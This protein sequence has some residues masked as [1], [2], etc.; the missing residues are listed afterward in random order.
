MRTFVKK[1]TEDLYLLRIDDDQTKYFEALWSIPEG[2]T[3]NAYLLIT[4]DKVVLFDSWKRT[5]ENEF[6]KCL[7]KVVDLKDIDY[8]VIHHMEQ[9]HSGAIPKVLEING[10]KAEV[11]GHPLVKKMLESFYGISPKFKA[12]ADGEE[13]SV[14]GKKLQFIRTPWLH[15]PET[16]MT[17]IS[18]DQ[19]L[20]SGDAFGGFS[21]PPTIIDDEKVVSEYLEHVRKYVVTIVGHYSEHILKAVEKLRTSGLTFKIIAPAHGL[22]FKNNPGLIVDYFVKLAKGIPEKNKIVVVYSSMYGSVEKA[23]LAAVEELEKNNFKPVIHKFTDTEQ[24]NIG[25]VISNIVDAQAV[26]IGAATYE[27][28]VFPYIRYLLDLLDKK[29]KLEKPVLVISS[30]GWGGVA[31][32]KISKKL[33]ESGFKVVDKIEFHGQPSESDLE[34]VKRSVRSLI[35]ID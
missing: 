17:F 4:S 12:L 20:L 27:G 14:S 28:D 6:I 10:N 22:V 32:L 7:E 34:N 21:T 2:V 13:I 18:D 11:W 16:I 23:I 33:S 31:G 15:W 30:Y 5:Y 25:D 29:V 24:S 9:D 1:I 35:K 8:I 26:I 3:Y 19:I